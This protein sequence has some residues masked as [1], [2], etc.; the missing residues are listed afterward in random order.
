MTLHFSEVIPVVR[1]I[2]E[3]RIPTPGWGQRNLDLCLALL[4]AGCMTLTLD[5]LHCGPII[6]A[7]CA[8][9]FV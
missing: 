9:A 1:G 3:V 2:A 8:H 6:P 4:L 7:F 5:S